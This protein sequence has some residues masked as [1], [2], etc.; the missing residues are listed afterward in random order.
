M[1]IIPPMIPPTT[2][3]V[4]LLAMETG[5][6]ADIHVSCVVG[7]DDL[8]VCIVGIDVAAVVDRKLVGT[9]GHASAFSSVHNNNVVIVILIT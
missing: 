2:T 6:S 9:S 1:A 5:R 7:D 8:G 3:D 4:M